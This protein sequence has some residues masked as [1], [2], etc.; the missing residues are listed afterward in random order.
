MSYL[1]MAHGIPNFSKATISFWFRVPDKSIVN[2]MEDAAIHFA[3]DAASRKASP[4]GYSTYVLPRL[5]AIIPLF[6]FGPMYEGYKIKPEIFESITWTT[7]TITFNGC[8][9]WQNLSAPKTLTSHNGYNVAYSKVL[10]GPSYIGLACRQD[11]DINGNLIPG[12]ESASLIAF[13]Q[14]D[15]AGT[16]SW[17]TIVAQIHISNSI[18]SELLKSE[19]GCL[20]PLDT[21]YSY[22]F[23][24]CLT[25]I[26][27]PGGEQRRT[28]TYLDQS[29]LIAEA[30]GPESFSAGSSNIPVKPDTWHHALISFDLS[31]SMTGLGTRAHQAYEPCPI[32]SGRLDDG[33]SQPLFEP[34]PV[35]LNPCKVF[36]AL[37][38]VDYAG[39]N[40]HGSDYPYLKF[41]PDGSTDGSYLYDYGA[42]AIASSN[43]IH[44]AESSNIAVLFQKTWYL[45]GLIDIWSFDPVERPTFTYA[46]RPIPAKGYSLGIPATADLVNAVRDVEMAEFQMFTE[47][48]IDTTVEKN[49]RAFIDYTRDKDGNPIVAKDGKRT[50]KPV[51]PSKAE[52]LIGKQPEILLH[53]SSN[54]INGKNT[55]SLGIKEDADG[56]QVL[57]PEGQLKPTAKIEKYKP[58]P[59]LVKEPA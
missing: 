3:A 11:S 46:P 39:E 48:M 22:P 20:P 47:V 9:G 54:W 25:D 41:N 40:L 18:Q 45:T 26:A 59:S 15:T 8:D 35:T 33:F 42:H 53:G 51:D 1:N 4:D 32:G 50:L 58:E 7:Q 5:N 37:D 34:G 56:K 43:V 27:Y 52:K 10:V 30:N 57:L 55:G 21:A 24:Q 36:I 2:C 23:Q 16:P 31:S 12:T 13:I 6:V 29:D 44:G 38:D 14:M 19:P 49:R 17:T 28:H